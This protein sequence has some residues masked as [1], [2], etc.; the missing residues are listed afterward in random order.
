MSKLNTLLL[1][2]LLACA[3]GAAQAAG[4]ANATLTRDQASAEHDRVEAT[5]KADKEACK[6]MDGNAKDICEAEAKGKEQVANAEIDY[7]RSGKDSDRMKIAETRAKADY[8]IAKERC[9]D[10]PK[11]E[12]S[13]CKKEAKAAEKAAIANAKKA[14]PAS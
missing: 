11:A 4:E 2:G 7:T 1:A 12:Q 3:G 10:R 14:H 8:A 13:V 5:Y 9:E 6:K